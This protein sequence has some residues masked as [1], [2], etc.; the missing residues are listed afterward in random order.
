MLLWFKLLSERFIL[1]GKTYRLKNQEVESKWLKHKV[2]SLVTQAG[3][4]RGDLS[5]C[6]TLSGLSVMSRTGR[7]WLGSNFTCSLAGQRLVRS[8]SFWLLVADLSI[9]EA[10]CHQGSVWW[11]DLEKGT[12]WLCPDLDI[13]LEWPSRGRFYQTS[14]SCRLA[15]FWL[16]WLWVKKWRYADTRW[17]QYKALTALAFLNINGLNCLCCT[18]I[19]HILL[20]ASTVVALRVRFIKTKM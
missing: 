13:T 16:E 17:C 1:T 19:L 8:C 20:L 10:T 12:Q 7:F 15:G 9:L 6:F 2:V 18:V 5:H 11:H 4:V 3:N 14:V